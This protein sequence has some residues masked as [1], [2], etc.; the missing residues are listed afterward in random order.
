MELNWSTS[1]RSEYKRRGEMMSLKQKRNDFVQSLLK[2]YKAH[3]GP[4]TDDSELK[5][6]IKRYKGKNKELKSTLRTEIQYQKHIHVRAAQLRPNLY[7]VNSLS[8]G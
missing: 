4:I 1:Q 6:M 3:N 7:K 5:A 8:D 2:K